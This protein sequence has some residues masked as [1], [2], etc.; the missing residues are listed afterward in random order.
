M[1]IITAQSYL[2]TQQISK[3]VE[4][5]SEA[6]VLRLVSADLE[7]AGFYPISIEPIGEYHVSA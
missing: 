2:T 3:T 4:A 7:D 5:A 6:E 1:F